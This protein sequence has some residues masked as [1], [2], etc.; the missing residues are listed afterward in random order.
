VQ[1]SPFQWHCSD[2]SS[3][4]QQEAVLGALLQVAQLVHDFPSQIA[5]EQDE[6]SENALLLSAGPPQPLLIQQHI[7]LALNSIP[8]LLN[9][10]M[11][12]FQ[13]LH[14]APTQFAMENHGLIAPLAIMLLVL[15]PAGLLM[16]NLNNAT[17]KEMIAPQIFALIMK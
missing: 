14:L 2:L 4:D 8:M 12:Q 13:M 6:A 7:K 5:L 15:L 9:A 3:A 17:G 10:S 11:V 16:T 1:S